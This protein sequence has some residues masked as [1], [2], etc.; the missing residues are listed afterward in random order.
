MGGDAGCSHRTS[1]GKVP[2]TWD[3]HPWTDLVAVSR[4]GCGGKPLIDD[5]VLRSTE[6]KS[7]PLCLPLLSESAGRPFHQPL[8][9]GF[10]ELPKL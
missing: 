5:T 10:A 2:N 4:N 7:A 1:R 9:R 8:D 3:P 6:E